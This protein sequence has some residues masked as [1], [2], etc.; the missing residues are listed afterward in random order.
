MKVKIIKASVWSGDGLAPKRYNVDAV[1]DFPKEVAVTAMKMGYAKL[2]DDKEPLSSG[3]KEP[4]D[5]GN[6]GEPTLQEKLDA[7]TRKEL[8][9]YATEL[10][11]DKPEKYPN[12]DALEVAIIAKVEEGKDNA[13]D[14]DA[15]KGGNDPEKEE[16]SE[17]DNE[18]GNGGAE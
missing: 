12:K 6:G 11:V 7:M 4:A 14:E 15:D 1:V 18:K 2:A 9:A 5:N 16:G 17:A 8:N 3:K 13:D 10:G